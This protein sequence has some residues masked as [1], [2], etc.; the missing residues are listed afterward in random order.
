MG[1][2]QQM[3][4]KQ[5]IIFNINVLEKHYFIYDKIHNH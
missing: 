4:K 3:Q 2:E 5:T 1:I